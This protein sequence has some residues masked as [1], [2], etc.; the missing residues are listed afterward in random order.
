MKEYLSHEIQENSSFFQGHIS[1]YFTK[2]YSFRVTK[3]YGDND[4]IDKINVAKYRPFFWR[5]IKHKLDERNRKGG[6]IRIPS[7]NDIEVHYVKLVDSATE[8]VSG[9]FQ[10]H[11]TTA[12]CT[13]DH[14]NRYFDLKQGKTCGH[15]SESNWDQ[16]TFMAFCDFCGRLLPF[17]YASNL[18]KDCQKCKSEGS[19]AILIW[20]RKDDLAS[21][22]VRCINDKCKNETGLFFFDCN[23]DEGKLSRKEKHG[24]RGVPTRSGTVIHPMVITLPDIPDKDDVS[25]PDGKLYSKL[26]SAAFNSFFPEDAEEALLHLP[27]LK[28]RTIR[29]KEFWSFPGVS[30]LCAELAVGSDY[31]HPDSKNLEFISFI[32]TILRRAKDPIDRGGDQTRIKEMYG[33]QQ[34]VDHVNSLKKEF[35]F[36]EEDLQG[37]YLLLEDGSSASQRSSDSNDGLLKPKKRSTPSSLSMPEYQSWLSSQGLQKIMHVENLHMIQSLLGIVEGSTR[38]SAPLF[39][40]INLP[41][42]NQKKPAVYV[43]KFIT[44]G[45]V[46]QLDYNNVLKWII[47]N[48]NSIDPSLTSQAVSP[49][50]GS[51]ELSYRKLVLKNQ[52]IRDSVFKLLHTFSHMLIQQSTIHTGLD[53]Q[54]LAEVIYPATASVFI[55]STNSINTGGLESTFD[56]HIKNWIERVRDLVEACPQDPSC[57]IDEGGA[58]NACSFVP[59]FVCC[60]FN[61]ELDRSTLLGKSSR[62]GT[63]FINGK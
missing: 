48:K 22:K 57:M 42:G 36:N 35:E 50:D 18:G 27:E 45:I 5:Q 31:F 15:D 46:F 43:R 40:T 3:N 19:L 25:G 56:F 30:L 1:Q 33:I 49:T 52:L 7:V 9:E 6:M 61:Q 4:A 55:Y 62:F 21:Y 37:T 10:I 60:K 41:R 63:G 58:C 59:E 17:H 11:P 54:S 23:H 39:N 16:I 26:L 12:L 29:T 8:G 53:I 44:E 28:E 47:K 34:L 13:K 2:G 51:P 20:R 14:C 32:K 24:F 38:G